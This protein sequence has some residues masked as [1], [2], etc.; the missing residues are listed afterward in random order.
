MCGLCYR[1]DALDNVNREG[2]EFS[3]PLQPYGISSLVA[4][5][6]DAVHNFL[7][8]YIAIYKAKW[9]KT[10]K[11]EKAQLGSRTSLKL[12]N[13]KPVRDLSE[14]SGRGGV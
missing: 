9:S 10:S 5:K 1:T 7:A 3:R 12:P 8:D 4:Q 6:K 13:L 14:V 2:N 11:T